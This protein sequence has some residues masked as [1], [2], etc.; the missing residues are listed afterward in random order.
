MLAKAAFGLGGTWNH[1][2]TILS[3]PL[4]S[5]R[6]PH[7]CHR[8]RPAALTRLEA[9]QTSHRR[10]RFLPDGRHFFYYAAGAPDVS[11]V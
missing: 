10:P 8:R 5:V 2:G 7:P 1:D 3:A 4:F 9:Q 11:G 6:S